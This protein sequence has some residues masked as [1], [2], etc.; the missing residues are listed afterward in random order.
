M[1]NYGIRARI[2]SDGERVLIINDSTGEV[3]DK[4]GYYKSDEVTK[5]QREYFE[6][7]ARQTQRYS[8]GREFVWLYYNVQTP[9]FKN[10]S[11]IDVARYI[12]ATTFCDFRTN[13]LVDIKR[14]PLTK[15]KL[16]KTLDISSSTFYRWYGKLG[17]YGYFYEERDKIQIPRHIV[18]KGSKTSKKK[19]MRIFTNETRHL[20]RSAKDVNKHEVGYLFKLIPYL[21]HRN[22]AAINRDGDPLLISDMAALLGINKRRKKTFADEMLHLNKVYGKNIIALTS[23]VDCEPENMNMIISTD[24]MFAGNEVELKHSEDMFSNLLR[25]NPSDIHYR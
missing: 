7:I 25:G 9:L 24:I 8:I 2:V 20:Y 17:A 15:D 3:I 11:S 14:R 4:P 6:S 10:M 21:H 12:Y 22:N 18:T 1:S 23:L 19:A 13:N 16:M 5:Q